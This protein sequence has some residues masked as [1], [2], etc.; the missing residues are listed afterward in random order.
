MHSSYTILLASLVCIPTAQSFANLPN[1][2]QSSTT[3]ASSLPTLT[4]TRWV[5]PSKWD[6]LVDE[7]EDEDDVDNIPVR[8]DM[9][10][11]PRNV[12]RAYDTFL[13]IRQ[14]GGKELTNDVY[15][16]DPEMDEF[17]Y[18]G[19]VARISDVSL[20]QCIARQWFMIERHATNLR[21]IELYPQRG[22]L[23]LWTAPGDSEI[24][25]A[26]N[27]PTLQM[28]KISKTVEGAEQVKKLMIGFQ[29][30]TYQPGEEGFRSWRTEEGLPARPEINP[31][32]ETRPPTDE[33]YAQIQK[34]VGKDNNAV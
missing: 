23:E 1:R 21:P 6:N 8:P 15:C 3:T 32:G 33:E 2:P 18:C 19:K 9:T 14:A 30:E 20:E 17:W 11:E 29:G 27:R 5:K 12:K 26:Y 16:R 25:V 31:G 13:S 24:E 7:D 4:T 34:E 28:T 22:R 10:Y